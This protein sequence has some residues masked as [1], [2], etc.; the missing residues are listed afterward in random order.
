MILGHTRPSV[1]LT[2]VIDDLSKV[3]P[4]LSENNSILFLASVRIQG[5][6]LAP[7][8]YVNPTI[9]PPYTK[10]PARKYVWLLNPI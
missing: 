3:I 10:E 2:T 5:L 6:P 8:T 1:K 4:M 7:P 9:E